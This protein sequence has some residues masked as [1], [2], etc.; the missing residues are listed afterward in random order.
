MVKEMVVNMV[1]IIKETTTRMTG[2]SGLC[3][4]F[5]ASLAQCGLPDPRCV[6]GMESCLTC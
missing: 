5:L 3:Q 1:N 2:D 6:P 4:L